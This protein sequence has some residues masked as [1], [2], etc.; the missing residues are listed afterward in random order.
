RKSQLETEIKGLEEKKVALNDS[1]TSLAQLME[2]LAVLNNALSEKSLEIGKNLQSA[3][4]LAQKSG[5]ELK[6]VFE[7]VKESAKKMAEKNKKNVEMTNIVLEKLP[8]YI[9]ELQKPIPIR[10]GPFPGEIAPN[11]PKKQA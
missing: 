10:R 8:K 1:I 3:S 4:T 2:R 11:K 7:E 6:E 9:F 5:G